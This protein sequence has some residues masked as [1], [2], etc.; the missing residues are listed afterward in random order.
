MRKEDHSQKALATAMLSNMD[1]SGMDTRAD[2]IFETMPPKLMT[3]PVSESSVWKGGGLKGGK[4]GV[5]LPLTR[6]GS[7]PSL[8]KR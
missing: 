1:S 4:P 8:F 6:K 3:S 5:M 2:P 7:L